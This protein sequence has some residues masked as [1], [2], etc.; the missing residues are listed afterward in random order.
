MTLSNKLCNVSLS[1]L[2]MVALT[3]VLVTFMLLFLSIDSPFYEVWGR[4]DSSWFFTA[5]KAWMNGM[6]PYVDFSDSKGPLLWLIYGI[7]Y[8][9]SN[10]DFVGVWVLTCI[11][12]FVVLWFIYGIARLFIDSRW[13]SL[14]VAIFM[15]FVYFNTFIH[16]ETKSEDFC[17]PYIAMGM[18]AALRVIYSK[19]ATDYESR[20]VSLLKQGAW[21]IGVAMGA[22]LLIKFTIALMIS[23]FAI[24]LCVVAHRA[25]SIKIWCLI[26]RMC[27]GFLL[28]CLPFVIYFA[29]CGNLDDFIREYFILTS[30]I[31]S[32]RPR[33]NIIGWVLSGGFLSVLIIIMSLSTGSVFIYAKKYAWVPLAAF[34]WFLLV[35]VQNAEWVYYYYSC[36]VFM[37][38]GFI[39]I[40]KCCSRFMRTKLTKSLVLLTLSFIIALPYFSHVSNLLNFKLVDHRHN[41]DYRLI[42]GEY[43]QHV[44]YVKKVHKPRIAFFNC[45]NVINVADET[46]GLPGCKYWS[47]QYGAT[48]MA[49]DQYQQ[50]VK[51]RPHFVYVK[52]KDKAHREQIEKLGYFL[53]LPP[54][55]VYNVCLY[56]LPELQGMY[57]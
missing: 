48:T 1:S 20:L 43:Y 19:C 47:K 37:V 14:C 17:Q 53:L 4:I 13:L 46:D 45:N 34:F 24:M 8:L 52:R 29:V 33:V 28:V 40:A 35:T 26:W 39:A 11:N 54:G 51:E 55:E 21:M 25:R 16:Y 57:R 9:M 10:H 3:I 42:I 56:A 18:W 38:F 50:I 36:M 49:Q 23:F 41:E 31:S 5:G 6:V 44:Q 2:I 32:H 27:V 7:G 15:I 12:Y 22:T 30:K